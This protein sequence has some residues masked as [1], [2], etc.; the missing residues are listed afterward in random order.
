MCSIKGCGNPTEARGWC[1]KHY[2]RWY[3]WGDPET[4]DHRKNKTKSTC[5][6]EG[7]DNEHAAKG[8]CRTHYAAQRRPGPGASYECTQC[9]TTFTAQKRRTS[10]HTF[11]SRKC[12]QDWSNARPEHRAKV[13]NSY[14]LRRYNLTEQEADELKTRGC[15]ICGRTEVS[16]R[17]G[18]NMHIDHNHTTGKV[19]G[20]LC[21]GCNVSLGHFQHDLDLL[22]RAVA[23][24]R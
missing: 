16:G 1:R 9:G 8:Y 20:V 12:K 23:Y 5:S 6:V 18:N 7:C 19:R 4:P 2:G 13:R 24:L 22:D 15:D 14:Y 10:E 3:R 11:C 17:W 21:H